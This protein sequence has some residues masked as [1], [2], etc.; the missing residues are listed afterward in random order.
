[1]A[2]QNHS[3][4]SLFDDLDKA[5]ELPAYHAEHWRES[6]PCH[7][8]GE[9]TM[10]SIHDSNHG[11]VFNGWCIKRLLLTGRIRTFEQAAELDEK[12]STKKRVCTSFTDGLREDLAW[13]ESHGFDPWADTHDPENFDARGLELYEA[14][15]SGRGDGVE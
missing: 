5:A 9:P 8:C 15:H 6:V 13:L 2:T 7:H 10:R 12:Y 1:M 11:A 14:K 4:L 3:Q